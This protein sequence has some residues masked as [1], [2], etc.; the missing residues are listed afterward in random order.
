MSEKSPSDSFN[1]TGDYA[2]IPG[3]SDDTLYKGVPDHVRRDIKTEIENTIQSGPKLSRFL[4]AALFGAFGERARDVFGLEDK[5]NGFEINYKQE[6]TIIRKVQNEYEGDVS[7]LKD[8]VRTS[9]NLTS[10]RDIETFH[11]YIMSDEGAM[12]MD[13][14]GVSLLYE[15]KRVYEEKREKGK[16]KIKYEPMVKHGF[17]Q[18]NKDTHYPALQYNFGVDL[19]GG[20]SQKTEVQVCH[21]QFD[22]D[23]YHGTHVPFDRRRQVIHRARILTEEQKDDIRILNAL[24]KKNIDPLDGEIKEYKQNL[25]KEGLSKSDKSKLEGSL[26]DARDARDDAYER[27][28]N[29]IDLIYSQAEKRDPTEWDNRAIDLYGSLCRFFNDH[30]A[31]ANAL[32][33]YGVKDIAKHNGE[34]FLQGDVREA[35]LDIVKKI[36]FL[37]QGEINGETYADHMD[38]LHPEFASEAAYHK[39]VRHKISKDMGLDKFSEEFTKKLMDQRQKTLDDLKKSMYANEKQANASTALDENPSV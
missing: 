8:A 11:S 25:K 16:D 21:K 19:G 39:K 14:Y 7:E 37:D 12:L 38:K 29:D 23:V 28:A 33:V 9:L 26:Q 17:R 5:D 36:K 32:D 15:E 27:H 10:I 13:I 4:D 24:F 31:Y 22:A 30:Y 20:Q 1:C 18:K 2:V 35:T 34:P 3:L 6:S